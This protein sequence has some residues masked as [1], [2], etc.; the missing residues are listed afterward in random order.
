D[1]RKPA[2]GPFILR[3]RFLGFDLDHYKLV[4]ENQAALH[5]I[6]WA[7]KSKRGL[8]S[9]YEDFPVLDNDYG[10][11]LKAFMSFTE[12]N[13]KTNEELFHDRPEIVRALGHLRGTYNS[14][15]GLYWDCD[16]GQKERGHTKD[17]ILK[18]PG[19]IV[20]DEVPWRTILHGDCWSNNM[21]FRYDEKTGRPVQ[22]IFIDLQMSRESDP[23]NDVCYTIF[24][25]AQPDVRRKHLQSMLHV[26]YDTFTGI[27]E[28]FGVE[29]LPGWSWKELNRRFHRAQIIGGF[30]ALGLHI[31]LKCTDDMENLDDAMS[32]L[33][34]KR[35]GDTDTSQ[36]MA[37]FFSEMVNAKKLHPAVLPRLCAVFEE[38]IEDGI[39]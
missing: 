22:V 8:D 39:L 23:M 5:A 11:M 26:Y 2:N 21:M 13:I 16:L 12:S 30:M 25:S 1:L 14:A 10:E 28:K 9:L 3:D 15:G 7:Y 4:I 6:S 33:D 17:T 35:E 36:K 31:M 29:P 20:E 24:T 27:C 37:D 32:K 38:L 19:E 18:V 34:T